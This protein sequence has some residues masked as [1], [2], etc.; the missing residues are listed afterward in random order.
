[1]NEQEI[2]KQQKLA[3][4]RQK[5]LQFQTKRKSSTS[6]SVSPNI[7][8][9]NQKQISESNTQSESILNAFDMDHSSVELE[10]GRSFSE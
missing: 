2:E 8:S 1:M 4:A 9:F 10:K 6:E 3:K 5:L 7:Q